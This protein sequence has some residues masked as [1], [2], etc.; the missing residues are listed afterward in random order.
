MSPSPTGHPARTSQPSPLRE[1][2]V[3]GRVPGG[4]AAAVMQSRFPADETQPRPGRRESN[5]ETI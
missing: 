4:A 2:P 5:K 1:L 3:L